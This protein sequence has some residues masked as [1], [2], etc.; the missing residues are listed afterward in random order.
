MIVFEK[1]LSREIKDIVNIKQQVTE[2]FNLLRDDRNTMLKKVD[3]MDY[4]IGQYRMDILGYKKE[5]GDKYTKK[6]DELTTKNIDLNEQ[7]EFLKYSIHGLSLQLEKSVNK[8][9]KDIHL[10]TQDFKNQMEKN[11]ELIKDLLDSAIRKEKFDTKFEFLERD[12]D[13]MKK[14]NDKIESQIQNLETYLQVY[15]PVQMKMYIDE[16]LTQ[17]IGDRKKYARI[18]KEKMLDYQAEINNKIAN[19]TAKKIEFNFKYTEPP[20]VM[21]EIDTDDAASDSSYSHIKNIVQD[22]LD[23]KDI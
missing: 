2:K 15:S 16:R 21:P 3:N 19:L 11:S 17:V 7:I 23:K 6:L 1:D 18:L 13:W 10:Q 9:V 5:I 14:R 12:V 20:A 8:E 22:L 4:E